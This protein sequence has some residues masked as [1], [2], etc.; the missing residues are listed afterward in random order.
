MNV[1]LLQ[2]GEQL[3]MDLAGGVTRLMRTGTVA[4]MLDA[5][6]HRVTW[7]ASTFNHTT[8]R[9]RTAGY[10]EV[11]L[12]TRSR[13]CLLPG[14]VYRRNVSVAR[15]VN[16]WQVAHGFARRA[17]L[18]PRP[19]VIVAAYPSIDLAHAAVRFA[20][21]HRIPVAVD[22]RD[23][24]PD[25]FIDAVPHWLRPLAERV[26]VRYDRMRQRTMQGADAI[27][28]TS[29]GFVDWGL[30]GAGRPRRVQDQ[31]FPLAYASPGTD[32]AKLA[33]AADRWATLLGPA[34]HGAVFCF[35]GSFGERVLD[36]APVISAARLAADQGLPYAFVLCGSGPA[37][38]A[39]KLQAQGLATV[40]FPGHVDATAVQAL[41]QLSQAG[42]VP[43]RPLWDFQLSL[44]N[45]AIEYL[46]AGLPV[47]ACQGG[48]LGRLIEQTGAGL[49]YEAGSAADLLR[50]LAQAL[51]PAFQRSA[52][53]AARTT[54]A[55]SFD[56]G[57]VYRQ[58]ITALLALAPSSS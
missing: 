30:R 21:Q 50:A 34:R 35:V 11:P 42:I 33:A 19:D 16:H 26:L 58:Y 3:P 49:A 29:D 57:V 54:F 28:G 15:L 47:L 14:R 43:Y 23:L 5:A 40:L 31:V 53:A 9:Q 13:A 8:K 45:K 22:V 2:S 48:E 38:D 56:A 37:L 6:G 41:L 36:L 1:W 27:W 20:R 4:R 51:D 46:S 17:R 18:E 32:T 55:A 7:W 10:A 25:I 39:F 24:W 12:F 52:R 44:P